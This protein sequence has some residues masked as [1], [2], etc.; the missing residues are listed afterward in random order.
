[1]LLAFCLVAGACSDSDHSAL[2][3]GSLG[4]V[5]VRPGDSVQIRSIS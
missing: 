5:R 3:D 1:M 4:V 2:S